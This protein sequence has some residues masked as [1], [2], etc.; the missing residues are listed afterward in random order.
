MA[1]PA[2]APNPTLALGTSA[3]MP[4]RC[5]GLARAARAEGARAVLY[6]VMPPWARSLTDLGRVRNGR[7]A[8]TVPPRAVLYAMLILGI[9]TAVFSMLGCALFGAVDPLHFGAFSRSYFT[10]FQVP[11]EI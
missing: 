1:A 10:M 4:A 6:A 9:V 2:Q 11:W 7:P 5:P 3:V 8:A